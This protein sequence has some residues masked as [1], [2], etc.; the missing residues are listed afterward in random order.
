MEKVYRDVKEE[1]YEDIPKCLV[2]DINLMKVF[3]GN[4]KGH[5]EVL[6][7]GAE[8]LTIH[9]DGEVWKFSSF[10]FYKFDGGD[11]KE[12]TMAEDETVDAVPILLSL[13]ESVGWLW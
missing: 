3:N 12:L 7:D 2:K 6:G 5:D 8:C 13:E 9:Y 10:A 1:D 11:Y 4:Y